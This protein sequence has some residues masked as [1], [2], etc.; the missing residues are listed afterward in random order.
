MIKKEK[1]HVH[2]KIDK[3]V[4]EKTQEVM[5]EMGYT[6]SGFVEMLFRQ[7]IKAETSPLGDIIEGILSDLL[8]K[9]TTSKKAKK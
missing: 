9:K 1:V 4:W 5:R 2:M 6:Q 8:E 3:E 7:M